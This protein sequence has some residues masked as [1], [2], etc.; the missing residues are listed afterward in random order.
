MT[1][2]SELTS[3]LVQNNGSGCVLKLN[4]LNHDLPKRALLNRKE[5]KIMKMKTSQYFGE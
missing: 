2:K 5:R 4:S 1:L 3:N